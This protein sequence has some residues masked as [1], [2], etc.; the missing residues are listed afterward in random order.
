MTIF[1]NQCSNIINFLPGLIIL[2]FGMFALYSSLLLMEGYANLSAH[3]VYLHKDV[4]LEDLSTKEQW[5]YWSVIA[6]GL[7]GFV[8]AV[9]NASKLSRLNRMNQEKV[10]TL[11]TF[12]N[13]LSALEMARDGVLIVEGNGDLSYANKSL[14]NIAGISPDSREQFIGKS[15]FE[16]FSVSDK[17]HIEEEILPLLDEDGYWFGN[18]SMYRLDNSV[19]FTEFSLT[20]LPDGGLVGTIQ[21]IS[22]K[23]RAEDE[24]KDLEEQFYQ[25][26]KMEAVG[27][28]AGGI[29]HDF[30]NILAAMNGYAEF[31]VDD[32][33]EGTSE[34]KFAHNILQAGMQARGLVDQMLAFSRR[35]STACKPLDLVSCVR[36]SI[37]M[38]QATLP[39]TVE[40]NENLQLDQ[41]PIS[42]SSTQISQTVM[43]LCVNAQDAM[44]DTHGSLEI[45]L[46]HIQLTKLNMPSS[47]VQESLPAV[48]DTPLCRIDDIEA[49]RTRLLLGHLA[50]GQDYVRLRIRDT[51]EGMSRQIMEHVFEP[52]FTT[53]PVGK[54]TGLGLATVHGIIVNHRG[55]M[56][57]DSR[58]GKGTCFDLYF[59]LIE[60]VKEVQVRESEEKES[61]KK[62]GGE[63][64]ILLVEDQAEVRDVVMTMLNRLGYEASFAESGLDGIDMVRENPDLYDLIIS[65]HNMPKMTGFEM[66]EQIHLDLPDLPVILLSGYSDE[67]LQDMIKEHPA[68]K[69]ILRKPVSRSVLGDEIEKILQAK[70]IKAA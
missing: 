24:K 18:F 67:G 22:E 59:P 33:E 31:L 25:A 28:L 48:E 52:F 68:I 14:F 27:R 34:H 64:H 30:N 9:L 35:G 57:I 8:L 54:G 1:K 29:A 40:L 39:K 62:T 66:I 69:T 7:S 15:W 26:Q 16:L 11:N 4:F 17:E 60:D 65:D 19:L 21:D 51:G 37:S 36:E 58:L 53:K 70:N 2:V 10:K 20:R 3:S 41:A 23:R 46:E 61:I 44:E 49:G 13:H 63:K 56:M 50:K 55:L 45:A 47:I 12:E 6:I 5:L 38:L 43:N 32:L 42:G